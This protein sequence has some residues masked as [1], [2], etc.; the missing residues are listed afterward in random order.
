MEPSSYIF[1]LR[2]AISCPSIP[3]NGV[4]EALTD[5][6][7]NDGISTFEA[8][9][10]R[11]WFP[12][13]TLCLPDPIFL[14]PIVFIALSA[15][16]LPAASGLNAARCV[17]ILHPVPLTFLFSIIAVI[18]AV[19]LVVSSKSSIPFVVFMAILSLRMVTSPPI[20]IDFLCPLLLRALREPS[21]AF[22]PKSTVSFSL[23]FMTLL[24]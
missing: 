24:S 16:S 7:S 3:R 14:P 21:S 10:V 4:L 17:P 12:K 13:I 11:G 18:F 19:R 6:R 22:H 20:M 1:K 5:D 23:I 2:D 8:M 9:S 15:A